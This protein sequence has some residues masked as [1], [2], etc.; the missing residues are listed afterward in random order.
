MHVRGAD[1]SSAQALPAVRHAIGQGI[2]FAFVKTTQGVDYVNPLA[3]Q[4]IATLETNGIP[5]GLYHFLTAEADGAAQWDHFETTLGWSLSRGF[6]AVDHESDAGVMPP[7]HIAQAFIRR[8][9]QRGYRVGRYGDGRVIRRNLGEAWKWVAWW[10]PTPPPFGWR[11]WQFSDG[12]G[13]QDWNVYNG[14]A[15]QL[16]QWIASLT[17]QLERDKKWAP[18][19]WWLHDDFTKAA[20]GPFLLPRLGAAIVTYLVRHPK[21]FRLRLERK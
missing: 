15:V 12:N 11:V 16:K 5:V 14:N 3:R 2:A 17:R 13:E 20:R 10:G 1:F 9:H 7:D 18:M 19:R 21:T 4:Q 8:G 6:V